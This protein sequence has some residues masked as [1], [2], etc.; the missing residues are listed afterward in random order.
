MIASASAPSAAA[1]TRCRIRNGTLRR[2]REGKGLQDGRDFAACIP[3]ARGLDGEHVLEVCDQL[4]VVCV[5]VLERLGGGPIDHRGERGR[6]LGP[7]SLDV[8]ERVAHVLH[9]HRD[10]ALAPE[11]DLPGEHLVKQHAQRVQVRLAGHGLPEGLLGGDVVGRT[12]H[13]PVGGQPL[14]VE[15]AGDAEVGDLA[16]AFFVYEHV[17]WFD[18]PVN[19][20]AGVR[21]PERAGD[22]DGVSDGFSDR[23]PA[24]AADALLERLALHVLEDDVWPSLVLAGIDH[25]HHVRMVELGDGARLAPEALELVR[26]RDDLAVHQLDRDTTLEG[27]IE[28]AVDRGHP[29]LTDSGLQ[30]VAAAQPRTHQRAHLLPLFCANV[31]VVQ[32][33]K[34]LDQFA[35]QV[36]ITYVVSRNAAGALARTVV[37]SAIR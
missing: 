33:T 6:D 37:A 5:A 17:L 27:L 26:V 31:S 29:A 11:R 4:G 36:R 25:A 13:A 16:G 12:Q 1:R 7:L 18:V 34:I 3:G 32:L 19:D 2:L 15:R 20:V 10:L 24:A 28:R 8:G 30:P 14:L 35:G 21:G 23:Q 9:R 22:L